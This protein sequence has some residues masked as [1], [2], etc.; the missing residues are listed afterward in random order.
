MFVICSLRH[1]V[2]Q[3]VSFSC[4]FVL[5]PGEAKGRQFEP[6]KST[7]CRDATRKTLQTENIEL[8]IPRKST[9]CRDATRKTD[10]EL[11]TKFL[12]PWP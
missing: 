5:K 3:S 12:R 7:V 9:V 8:H 11:C 6:R 2:S 1:A 10:K 4:V